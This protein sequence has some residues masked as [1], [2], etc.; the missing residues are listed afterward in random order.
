ME[1][2]E[3]IYGTEITDG[4]VLSGIITNR[5]SVK[6]D[7]DSINKIAEKD[8]VV[9]EKVP[10]VYKGYRLVYIDGKVYTIDT[11]LFG[12]KNALDSFEEE[13]KIGTSDSAIKECSW[14]DYGLEK[15]EEFDE[16]VEINIPWK[17]V[18]LIKHSLGVDINIPLNIIGEITDSTVLAMPCRFRLHKASFEIGETYL[19]V[20]DAKYLFDELLP[21]IYKRGLERIKMEFEQN[22]I[23]E[24]KARILAEEAKERLLNEPSLTQ[25]NIDNDCENT[26]SDNSSL[27]TI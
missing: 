25:N 15:T 11:N 19:N 17:Y 9:E 5:P 22:K 14:K 26:K 2:S 1:L 16:G 12:G 13:L 21:F 23:E 8:F 27:S 20:D 6:T 24:E 4:K 18:A 3:S 10:F 7:L